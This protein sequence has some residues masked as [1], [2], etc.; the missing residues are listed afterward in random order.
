LVLQGQHSFNFVRFFDEGAQR[1]KTTM[2]DQEQ[3]HDHTHD[4]RPGPRYLLISRIKATLT[5]V[6]KM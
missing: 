3:N 4:K 1:I 6:I 2:I 5:G